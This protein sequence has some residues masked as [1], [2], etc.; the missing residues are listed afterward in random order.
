MLHRNLPL[1]A[2]ALAL[3]LFLWFW[4]LFTQRTLIVETTVRAPVT[5]RDLSSDLVLERAV[6]SVEVRLRGMKEEMG[7]SAPQVEVS[8]SCAGLKA[9]RYML[10]AE[11][12]VPE[13]LT[14]VE[15]RPLRVEVT[16]EPVVSE[17]KPV[18]LSLSG[19][20][21]PE[22]ELLGAEVQPKY[23]QVSGPRSKVN[24]VARLLA[25]VDLSRATP[26]LPL[27]PAIQAV[28]RAGSKV[29]GLTLTPGRAE[30]TLQVKQ[31]LVTR[32]VPV[33]VRPK[34]A[35]APGYRVTSVRVEPAVVTVSGP[36][37]KLARL[38]Q[39]ETEE[40]QLEGSRAQVTRQLALRLPLGVKALG[41]S[42]VTVTVEVE[43]KPPIAGA[44]D[45]SSLR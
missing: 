30:V 15:V 7:G 24:R 31:A 16:I 45:E 6:P 23:A 37:D 26:E 18:E 21:A 35:P 5:A 36:A 40:L 38:P 14:V 4:V 44:G 3:A 41:T 12:T 20:L 22:Y 1:K 29:D 19:T 17:A 25:A 2:A 32:T 42:V 28:D 13:N 8:V 39:V 27:V 43:R 10:P 33:V 34:G 11:V 9:G